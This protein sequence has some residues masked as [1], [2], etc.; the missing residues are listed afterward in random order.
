MVIELLY[1]YYMVQTSSGKTHTM[2]GDLKSRKWSVLSSCYEDVF[3]NIQSTSDGT[4]YLLMVSFLEIYNEKIYDLFDDKR[5]PLKT[6]EKKKIKDSLFQASVNA[7]S[8][9]SRNL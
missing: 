7:L 5:I 4:M 9:H 2:I 8:T 3:S 1:F 6:M